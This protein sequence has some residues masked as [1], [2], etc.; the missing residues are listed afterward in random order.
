MPTRKPSTPGRLETYRAKRTPSATPEP[1]G[2]DAA[3]PRL[4]VVQKHA[5]T[6]L[7]WDFRLEWGGTLWSWAIPQGPSYDPKVRRL[8]VQVEDHPV[9]YADFVG[10]P[11]MGN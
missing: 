1:F 11:P 4:F 10:V 5:A 9:E 3:R 6:R 8:A 2:G 7:H